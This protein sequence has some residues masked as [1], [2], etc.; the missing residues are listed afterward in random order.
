MTRAQVVRSFRVGQNARERLARRLYEA[1]AREYRRTLSELARKYGQPRKQIKLSAAIRDELMR[2]AKANA[3]R[4]SATTN[5]IVE[6]EARRR[7]GL[8]PTLLHRHLAGY[9]AK[10]QETRAT[11][12]ARQE[13]VTPH[14]D[15]TVAFFRE[16]GV[17]PEFD[18]AGPPGKCPLCRRLKETGPHSVAVVLAIGYPHIGCRHAWRARTRALVALRSG[19]IRPGV[20][21]AGRG[22]TAG[23]VNSDALVNRAGTQAEALELLEAVT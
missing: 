8:T 2:E 13:L 6:D 20:I 12:I 7:R 18:F 5:R 3:R 9:M 14:L 23:I 11:L 4:I 22:P 1:K 21:S 15:A 17:E 16:N 19:G 10:R